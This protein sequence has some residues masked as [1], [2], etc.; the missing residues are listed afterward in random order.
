MTRIKFGIFANARTAIAVALLVICGLSLER[1]GIAQTSAQTP[2]QAPLPTQP[3]EQVFKNIQV[4]KGTPSA[5]LQGTMSFIASSLG[6]DC[7]YCH[8]QA[9]E[10][11]ATPAKVRA[12]EMIRM[13]Q[14]IN[15]ETFHGSNVVNCFTCH[16]GGSKPIS[17]ATVLTTGAAR[18]AAATVASPVDSALP[19]VQTVLDN[20][21]KALGGQA[22][23]DAVKTRVI[24]TAPLGRASTDKSTEERDLKAPGKV[25]LQQLSPGYSLWAGYNG[26]QGWAQDSLKSY[27]GMLNTSQLHSLIR[28][29]E[30]YPGSRIRSEYKNVV[31][32]GREKVAD[33]DAIVISGISPEGTREKFYFDA[34]TNLL[35]RRHV[36]EP[37]E[38]GWFPLDTNYEG[39]REVDGVKI[40]FVVRISS[41]GG[42][43][44]VRTSYMVIE[45]RQ[46]VPIEDEKFEHAP[47]AK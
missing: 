18:P 22:A 15:Q 25:L 45:V 17:I 41:A 44:G 2:A 19:S 16:Q 4:L 10:S 13:T 43:W 40:P 35:V 11:D 14:R 29:G 1:A 23:L 21:V 32:S 37:T 38:F 20:Y 27:W 5:D 12:R 46:N 6:V 36:E 8:T 31:V 3:A 39:Y 30:M 26:Q 42:A 34:R 24:K 33:R 47:V 9:F 28:D 7:D